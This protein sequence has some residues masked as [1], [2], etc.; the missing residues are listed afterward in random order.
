[1]AYDGFIPALDRP[2][3]AI[4]ID[5]QPNSARPVI[6]DGAVKV[7]DRFALLFGYASFGAGLGVAGAMVASVAEP[8][9]VPV[10]A[11]MSMLGAILIARRTAAT[12]HWAAAVLVLVMHLSAM[13]AVASIFMPEL[14]AQILPLAGLF[15]AS[16][17][18][19]AIA[20]G[21]WFT[22]IMNV[23]LQ[24]LLLSAPFGAAFAHSFFNRG[25]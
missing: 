12:L 19:L 13:A 22:T 7:Q 4:S 3:D 14:K 9:L 15:A 18:A 25:F 1:M 2:R 24:A 11:V 6:Y 8:V 16:L 10:I 21:R 23:A 20:Y 5:V 17:I